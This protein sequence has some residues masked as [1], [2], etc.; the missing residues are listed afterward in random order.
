MCILS[1][2]SCKTFI[3]DKVFRKACETEWLTQNANR[4]HI[5]CINNF[6][7][8]L[9]LLRIIYVELCRTIGLILL[10]CNID[11]KGLFRINNYLKCLHID[12]FSCFYMLFK[13]KLTVYIWPSEL[14]CYYSYVFCINHGSSCLLPFSPFLPH[15]LQ[16]YRG[17]RN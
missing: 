15:S 13:H 1:L 7:E 9:I 3:V 12:S 4:K 5:S 10:K 11:S 6:V 8:Y 16:Q 14:V 17:W 2:E